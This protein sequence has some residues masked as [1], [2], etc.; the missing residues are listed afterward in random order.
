[1]LVV[2]DDRGREPVAEEMA[3]PVVAPIEL[4][5]VR[6]VHALHPRRQRRELALDDEVQV[7][8]HQAPHEDPPAALRDLASEEREE[9]EPFAVVPDDGG[10][11][12]AENRHVV[13][14]D[15]RKVA[16]RD[17]RHLPRR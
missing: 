16:A 2:T 3:A 9:E 4:L 14:P 15:R 8:V 6:P 7:G 10:R 12:D 17:S 13:R 1:M 11:G 5:S